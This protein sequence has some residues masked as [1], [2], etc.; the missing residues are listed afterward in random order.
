MS[1]DSLQDATAVVVLGSVMIWQ[2]LKKQKQTLA[3][4]A[5]TAKS[6]PN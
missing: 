1:T 3:S 2:A 5:I 4:I 6:L